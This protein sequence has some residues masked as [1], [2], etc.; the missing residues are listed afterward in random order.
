V[1][2]GKDPPLTLL[3]AYV[4]LGGRAVMLLRTLIAIVIMLLV[5]VGLSLM[6]LRYLPLED[7]VSAIRD[8]GGLIGEVTSY[9]MR[10]L[11]SVQQGK[12]LPVNESTGISQRIEA[13]RTRLMKIFSR[14]GLTNSSGGLLVFMSRLLSNE[15]VVVVKRS[16][17][18]NETVADEVSNAMERGRGPLLS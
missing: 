10:G 12:P 2:K 6:I 15:S 18:S 4:H 8:M 7:I 1:L 14:L 5:L 13:L 16:S 9:G 11:E 3:I 17:L